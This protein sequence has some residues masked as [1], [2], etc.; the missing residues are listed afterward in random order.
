MAFTNIDIRIEID[1]AGVLYKD[2]AA[3]MGVN[4]ASLSRMMRKPLSAK[5]RERILYAL[6]VLVER[7]GVSNGE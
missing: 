6:S 1:A 5:Q 2:I 4:P 3:A 7:K